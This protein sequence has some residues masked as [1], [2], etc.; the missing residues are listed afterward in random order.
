MAYTVRRGSDGVL[1]ALVRAHNDTR[2]AVVGTSFHADVTSDTSGDFAN[3]VATAAT[4]TAA[5]ATNLATSLTLVNDLRRRMLQ[6]FGDALG[7]KVADTVAT[8]AVTLP[9]ATILDE[10]VALANQ[11]K[12][13]YNTHRASTTYHYTA[14]STNAVTA[15]N[16]D[17]QT[18]LNTLLNE[19]KG[20]F[21]A[22]I[23]SA[24]AGQ[25]INIV[26]P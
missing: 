12:S 13:V 14:D 10:A 26:A 21:N 17:D 15:D 25:S 8:A 23:A 18:T 2:R 7:H 24:P 4:V 1:A 3:P 9:Q 5:N 16:A 20:D 19:M 6:H 11:L 22:H